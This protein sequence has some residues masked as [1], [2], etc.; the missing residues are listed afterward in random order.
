M[1][2]LKRRF[3]RFYGVLFL[4]LVVIAST[5]FLLF[6]I[7]VTN[8]SKFIL[9]IIFSILFLV[10]IFYMVI[11]LLKA[12]TIIQFDEQHIKIGKKEYLWT[13]FREIRFSEIGYFLGRHENQTVLE[14]A[15]S[16]QIII[17]NSYYSNF[18]AFSSFI[19]NHHRDLGNEVTP[20]E[21]VFSNHAIFKK[22]SGFRV[23][24]LYTFV[25]LL[26]FIVYIIP[27]LSVYPNIVWG[28]PQL[29]VFGFVIIWFAVLLYLP[30]YIIIEG[31]ELRIQKLFFPAKKTVY[32]LNDLDHLVFYSEGRGP[33]KMM[34][35]NK[36]FVARSFF[37]SN[38][39]SIDLRD[40]VKDM[41][42]AGIKV[43]NKL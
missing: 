26:S 24:S 3:A 29:I 43:T 5:V 30:N 42:M 36:K 40:L 38:I 19:Q 11:A 4:L 6:N 28:W 25:F 41:E 32:H 16:G 37:I 20:Q 2:Q 39:S 8:Q 23:F 10:F 15:K 17:Y 12:I 14:K 27:F 35:I 18:A 21:K 22:Y 31:N 33:R 1:I 34:V 7:E 13:D 9:L